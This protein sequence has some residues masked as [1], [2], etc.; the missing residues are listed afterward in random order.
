MKSIKILILALLISGCAKNESIDPDQNQNQTMTNNNVINQLDYPANTPSTNDY[1]YLCWGSNG[2]ETFAGYRDW[3]SDAWVLNAG[4]VAS[5]FTEV[6]AIP[7][8]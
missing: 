2:E 4:E 6:G 5:S 3:V 8:K 1:Q 7:V